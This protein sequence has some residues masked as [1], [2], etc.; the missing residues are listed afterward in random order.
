MLRP[1]SVRRFAQ[2]AASFFRADIPPARGTK[3]DGRSRDRF[4]R[5]PSA[6]DIEQ[7]DGEIE[8]DFWRKAR[9]PHD[10]P[11]SSGPSRPEETC[12]LRCQ[13]MA[14]IRFCGHRRHAYACKTYLAV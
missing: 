5:E 10:T 2:Q 14:N 12:E 1:S 6:G 11:E 13:R 7:L 4:G 9:L 3:T 8:E